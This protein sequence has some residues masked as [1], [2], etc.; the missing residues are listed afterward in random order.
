MGTIIGL[1]EAR[2][3]E[4]E[5]GAIV[6]GAIVSGE[7]ILTTFS[8]IDINAGVVT[9]QGVPIGGSVGQTLVKQSPTDFD[10]AWVT[11]TAD[12]I[13]ETDAF[14]IM[15]A[16]E[17]TSIATLLSD[18]D[19][20]Q[21]VLFGDAS[22]V[23]VTQSPVGLIGTAATTSDELEHLIGVT[24]GIQAQFTPKQNVLLSVYNP[25]YSNG[26]Y[27]IDYAVRNGYLVTFGTPTMTASAL[28]LTTVN[29]QSGFQQR[30]RFVNGGSI[31]TLTFPA[32]T[33]IGGVAPTSIA[34][35]KTGVLTLISYG[36]TVGNTY[37]KWDVEP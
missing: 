29:I 28:T 34:A 32:F 14:K 15:T 23:L 37:A 12:I 2:M 18:V 9:P 13:A 11:L 17:R 7:L 20:K 3:L 36:S 21:D 22:K 31:K 19:L 4:I 5:A 8:G 6:S 16:A 24:S 10:L 27:V 26:T 25:G 1:T 33:Y 35:N 30:I